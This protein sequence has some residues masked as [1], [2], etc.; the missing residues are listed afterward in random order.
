MAIVVIQK[1]QAFF[2]K[3]LGSK[4]MVDDNIS[5]YYQPGDEQGATEVFALLKDKR[6]S[7]TRTPRK[8]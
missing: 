3:P 1:L 6:A 5:L 8:N 7:C 2:P 4:S